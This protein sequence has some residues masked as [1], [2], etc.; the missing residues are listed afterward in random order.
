MLAFAQVH[1]QSMAPS[2]Q[3]GDYVLYWPQTLRLRWQ[4]TRAYQVG[5]VVLVNHPVYGRIIKR[6]S[7]VIDQQDYRL[8]GDNPAESTSSE[9][10]G[11]VHHRQ[12]LGRVFTRIAK[13]A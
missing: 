13:P 4:P 11:K 7:E 3:E 12:C 9:A 1:G 6:I 2:Y 8:V 10:M 5:D